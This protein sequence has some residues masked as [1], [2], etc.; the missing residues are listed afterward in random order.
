MN[1]LAI[2]LVCVIIIILYIIYVYAT[3]TSLTSGLQKLKEPLTFGPNKLDN[4]GSTTYSYQCWLFMSGNTTTEIALFKRSSDPTKPDFAVSLNNTTL[5]IKAGKGDITPKLIMTV[6]DKFPLQKWVYLVIN[7]YNSGTVEAYMNG[8]L[9]KTVQAP[10]ADIKPSAVS[11]LVIGNSSLTG[12]VTKFTRLPITLDAQTV[13]KNYYN[14]NGISNIFS[15]LVPY[16]LNLTISKGE[17]VQR[18]ITVF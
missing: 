13:Q 6:T 1:Y 12:Y 16:G 11:P 14:G 18:S 4:P 2:V 17:D 8:R 3:N 7:V 10:A 5:T 9:I 15:T